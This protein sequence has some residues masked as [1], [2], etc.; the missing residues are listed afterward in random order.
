LAAAVGLL[1]C[2]RRVEVLEAPRIDL[3]NAS[4]VAVAVGEEVRLSCSATGARTGVVTYRWS[5][6]TPGAPPDALEG[7]AVAFQPKRAG[8]YVATCTASNASGSDIK[9]ASFT[10]DAEGA[11]PSRPVGKLAQ[12]PVT[13]KVTC[14]KPR[15]QGG[16]DFT[17]S[18]TVAGSNDEPRLTWKTSLGTLAATSGANATVRTPRSARRGGQQTAQ[19]EVEAATATG[20]GA[21][22]VTVLVDL[23][24][25]PT[26]TLEA[27]PT[28][29]FRRR[30]IETADA[31]E[32]TRDDG[33]AACQAQLSDCLEQTGKQDEC[34]KSAS[35]CQSKRPWGG[36]PGGLDCCPSS[37]VDTYFKAR[38]DKCADD[39]FPTFLR[40]GCY[41][42]EPAKP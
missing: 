1:G 25:C 7:I 28:T 18:A 30:P 40:E 20:V 6:S 10:V 2:S 33:I 15:V 42:A 11:A 23:P 9:T 12:S 36:D 26:A 14:D 5:I 35:R 38:S 16:D 3:V 4:P 24:P 21:G 41:P 13:V 39:V 22:S 19:I 32:R 8:A 34:V 29:T 17:C 37:C 27:T 31:G